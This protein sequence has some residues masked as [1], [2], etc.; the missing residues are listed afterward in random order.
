V[1]PPE[2]CLSVNQEVL[3]WGKQPS[4][5]HKLCGLLGSVSFEDAPLRAAL[6]MTLTAAAFRYDPVCEVGLDR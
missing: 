6:M 1:S 4:I 2:I 5:A 3:L